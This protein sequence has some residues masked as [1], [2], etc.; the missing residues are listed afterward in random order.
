MSDFSA[1]LQHEKRERRI[2]YFAAACLLFVVGL[3]LATWFI[4]IW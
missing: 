4:Y 1:I 3:I 2:G